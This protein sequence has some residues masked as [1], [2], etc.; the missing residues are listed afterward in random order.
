MIDA[1]V[2]DKIEEKQWTL[3]HTTTCTIAQYFSLFFV[4]SICEASLKWFEI[5]TR[6]RP[7]VY[8]APITYCIVSLSCSGENEEEVPPL[9]K[10]KNLANSFL[11]SAS[12]E[13]ETID[14]R[15]APHRR[16]LQRIISIEEDH[17]PQL[18]QDNYQA[19]SHLQE[20]SE[21]E[22]ATE[23][24][25]E[26]IDLVMSD[27]YPPTSPSKQQHQGGDVVDRDTPTSPRGQPV[28]KETSM[29]VSLGTQEV[30]KHTKGCYTTCTKY[31]CA[32]FSLCN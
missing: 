9:S 8:H 20:W 17:L 30:H 28:G 25:E 13:E 29:N 6:I 2:N 4:S 12:L 5:Q 16:Y 24:E 18:L 1:L 3:W 19:R 10:R 14:G 21:G 23:E 22:E 27:I 11:Q 15:A 32:P 26:N 7:S 31:I